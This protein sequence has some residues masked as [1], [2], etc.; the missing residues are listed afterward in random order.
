MSFRSEC[1]L[2]VF[3][4]FEPFPFPLQ[5]W[6]CTDVFGFVFT[7]VVRALILQ[8]SAPSTGRRTNNATKSSGASPLLFSPRKQGEAPGWLLLGTSG[9]RAGGWVHV[10]CP[11]VVFGCET[12]GG[13]FHRC[14]GGHWELCCP[15]G[16]VPDRAVKCGETTQEP[17]CAELRPVSAG[18]R[19]WVGAVTRACERARGLVV[20]DRAWL[21]SA[22]GNL[23]FLTSPFWLGQR[24]FLHGDAVWAWPVSSPCKK[25]RVTGCWPRKGRRSRVAGLCATVALSG[26]VPALTT[27]RAASRNSHEN[28]GLGSLCALGSSP[29]CS[30]CSLPVSLWKAPSGRAGCRVDEAV[31]RCLSTVPTTARPVPRW[32]VWLQ[33]W[34]LETWGMFRVRETPT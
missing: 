32:W 31:P 34:M 1:C 7:A 11:P 5:S 13:S 15:Q 28:L 26:A 17:Q 22:T 6:P 12:H 25:C 9:C 2:L 4:S 8:P 20:L 16:C 14:R 3:F 27:N 30:C 10:C 19:S 18:G 29:A 23:L 24:S 33:I 21:L